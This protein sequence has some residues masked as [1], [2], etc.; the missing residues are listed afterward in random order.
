MHCSASV[1]ETVWNAA[2]KSEINIY[3]LTL[4]LTRELLCMVLRIVG[5]HSIIHDLSGC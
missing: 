4:S 2:D 1:N 3:I 5:I